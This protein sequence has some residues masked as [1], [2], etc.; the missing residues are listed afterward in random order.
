MKKE[1]LF[2]GPFYEARLNF[3]AKTRERHHKITDLM[4]IKAKIP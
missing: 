4:S 2:S 1:E 3:D